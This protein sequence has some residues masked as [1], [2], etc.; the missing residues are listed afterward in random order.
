[1]VELEFILGVLL[2]VVVAVAILGFHTFFLGMLTWLG[3]RLVVNS[4]RKLEAEEKSKEPISVTPTE[5]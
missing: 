3:F 2:L 1:M 4:G 5:D